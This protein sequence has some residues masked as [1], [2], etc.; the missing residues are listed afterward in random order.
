MALNSNDSFYEHFYVESS[1][2]WWWDSNGDQTCGGE[3][4]GKMRY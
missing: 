1:S 3:D 4:I 2:E